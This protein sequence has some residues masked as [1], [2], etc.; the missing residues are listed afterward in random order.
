MINGSREQE[1]FNIG[2]LWWSFDLEMIYIIEL[3]LAVGMT[4]ESPCDS[5]FFV[6]I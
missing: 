3:C 6:I 1:L 5:D 2:T 4:S